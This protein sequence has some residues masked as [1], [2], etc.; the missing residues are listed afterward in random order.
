MNDSQP[1][2]AVFTSP[3][4]PALVLLALFLIPVLL[5]AATINV[6]AGGNLQA[7]I[8]AAQPG[9]TILLQAGATFEGSFVLRYKAGAGTN[10]DWIILRTS[11]PASSLPVPPSEGNEARRDGLR[12][13]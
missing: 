6:N 9:D 3:S 11:T 1:G 13:S 7:A 4:R 12:A 10:A 5:R 2:A 8:D